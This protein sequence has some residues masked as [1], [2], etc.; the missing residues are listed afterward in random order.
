MAG[1]TCDGGCIF[2]IDGLAGQR[3]S[4][5]WRSHAGTMRHRMVEFLYNFGEEIVCAARARSMRHIRAKLAN[6][7]WWLSPSHLAYCLIRQVV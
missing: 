1:L 6:G 7:H 4:Q 5:Y 3:N 2:L